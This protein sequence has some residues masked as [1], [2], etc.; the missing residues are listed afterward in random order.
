MFRQ[1]SEKI[2]CFFSP[3]SGSNSY[4]LL[5][6]R[7]KAL[8]DSSTGQNA[9]AL[10]AGLSALNISPEDISLILHTHCHADHLGNSHL[11]PKAA[12]AMHKL[13][14][15]AVNAK[16]PKTT[17]SHFFPETIFPKISKFLSQNKSLGL[18]SL[19]LKT[20]HC[21]GHTAGSLCFFLEKEGI[22]FSGDVLFSSGFGRTDLS[23]GSPEKMLESLKNLQKKPIKVL[24]SGHGPVLA[25]QGQI[26][27]HL[28]KTIEIASKD[29]L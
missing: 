1:I 22:L 21:P 17:C 26:A 14:G 15:K 13:D 11:F 4:L 19:S 16:D 7:E 3:N 2:F 20:I 9:N 29:A 23:S 12:K 24:L 25:G 10:L 28:E 6:Q 27:Q 18:G 5:G 8:I